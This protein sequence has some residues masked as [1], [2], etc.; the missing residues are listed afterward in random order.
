MFKSELNN[1]PDKSYSLY[2]ILDLSKLNY[3]APIRLSLPTPVSN[4]VFS[5]L[6]TISHCYPFPFIQGM[7]FIYSIYLKFHVLWY[8]M[9]FA[10][11]EIGILFSPW[12][13]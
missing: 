3:Y 11:T 8:F 7:V 12:I 2:Y 9:I 5:N 6:Q 13:I 10:A 1:L 4:Q